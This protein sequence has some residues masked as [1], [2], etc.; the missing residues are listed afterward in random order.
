MRHG[1]ETT[2]VEID[3]A[4]YDA[5]KRF[6]G[7]PAPPP[8]R[9]VLQDAKTWVHNRSVTVRSGSGETDD[10]KSSLLPTFE[11]FDVVVHDCF[12]GGSVPAH[13]YTQSFWRDLKDI[14][15]PDAVVAVVSQD[16]DHDVNC[17]T[18]SAELRGVLELKIC[19]SD[20][21]HAAV[22]LPA[23]PRILRCLGGARRH[24]Q[25]VRQLGSCRRC[26]HTMAVF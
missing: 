21:P 2:L 7:L 19:E 9:L 16:Y 15:T 26:Y 3:P 25:R 5:A 12:S 4:V 11:R 24:Q 10:S 22:C 6:F 20:H 23:M 17:L 14:V 18:H 8:E 1:I 13:L